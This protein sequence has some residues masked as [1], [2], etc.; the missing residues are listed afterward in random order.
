[1]CPNRDEMAALFRYV[2][3][4]GGYR[5]SIDLLFH[6]LG[7]GSGKLLVALDALQELGIAAYENRAGQLDIRL[8]P[9]K[10]KV[11]LDD[12]AVLCELR[13]KRNEAGR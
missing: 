11:N 9:T 12:S 8:L 4:Q 1:M 13:R 6:R 3:A 5:G 10:G 2:R 7:L